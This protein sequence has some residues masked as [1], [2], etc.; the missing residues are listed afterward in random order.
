[1]L[2]SLY[3]DGRFIWRVPYLKNR[4]VFYSIYSGRGNSAYS[5]KSCAGP[6]SDNS[7]AQGKVTGLC[8]ISTDDDYAD[9]DWPCPFRWGTNSRGKIS[10]ATNPGAALFGE[11]SKM[12]STPKR[13]SLPATYCAVC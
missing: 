12:A 4:S 8:Q 13:R 1:V 5:D 10:F 11:P 6:D 2:E 7:F 3:S 9:A